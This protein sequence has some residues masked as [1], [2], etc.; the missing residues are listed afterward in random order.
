MNVYLSFLTLEPYIY[1]GK[2]VTGKENFILLN[3]IVAFY[4]LFFLAVKIIFMVNDTS[5]STASVEVS[6]FDLLQSVILF[7][8]VV[9]ETV[10]NIFF[11]YKENTSLLF[12][13]KK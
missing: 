5:I 12:V 11:M 4:F 10:S 8:R 9:M 3:I 6:V 1:V 7:Y 2:S 13:Y